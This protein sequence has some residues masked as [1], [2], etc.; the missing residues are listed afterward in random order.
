[1]NPTLDEQ[2]RVTVERCV[3]PI[4]AT[5][6]RKDRMRE[7]LYAHLLALYEQQREVHDNDEAATT[8]AREQ[9]GDPRDIRDDLQ[10]SVPRLERLACV[11]LHPDNAQWR[12]KPDESAFRYDLRTMAAVTTLAMGAYFVLVAIGHYTQVGAHRPRAMT[13]YLVTASLATAV[14]PILFML[15][16]AKR[17]SLRKMGQAP[18]AAAV[19]TGATIFATALMLIAAITI[20]YIINWTANAPVVAL[21]SPFL[22]VPLLLLT[23]VLVEWQGRDSLRAARRFELWERLSLE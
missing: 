1:M 22:L 9:F 12:R 19:S 4:R 8:A 23:P 5:H 14:S 17:E 10:A 16:T 7:E 6:R 21:G 3:R 11:R 15:N 2:L 20:C 13:A 18:W